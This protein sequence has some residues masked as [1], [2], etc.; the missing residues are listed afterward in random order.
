MVAGDPV[1]PLG[2]LNPFTRW[3]HMVNGLRRRDPAACVMDQGGQWHSGQR[4]RGAME[5]APR[6]RGPGQGRATRAG[7]CD[8][9]VNNFYFFKNP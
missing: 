2:E 7:G 4:S 9:I 8:G 3:V 1:H 5:N 6:I